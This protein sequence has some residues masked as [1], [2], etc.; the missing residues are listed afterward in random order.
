MEKIFKDNHDG[1]LNVSVSYARA[2]YQPVLT[3]VMNKLLEN[4][5]VKGFRKGKAPRDLAMRYVSNEDLYNGM[6]N[7]IID[8]DFPTLLDGFDKPE[9][10][11]EYMKEKMVNDFPEYYQASYTIS[12]LD[13]TRLQKCRKKI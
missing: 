2:D 1:T 12:F 5:T 10:D 6:V 7:K 9:D 8:R 13:E 11:I 3:K 4:V